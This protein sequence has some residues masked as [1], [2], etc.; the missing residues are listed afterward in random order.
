L[1]KYKKEERGRKMKFEKGNV[2]V[3][4]FLLNKSYKR[5]QL[6]DTEEEFLHAAEFGDIPTVKRILLE[7]PNLNADCIDIITHIYIMN[8]KYTL[9]NNCPH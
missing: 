8:Q 3:N 9:Y 1:G 7:N 2:F 6:A 5:W 4:V